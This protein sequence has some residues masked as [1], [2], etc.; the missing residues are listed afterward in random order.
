MGRAGYEVR[1]ASLS[2]FD[3]DRY[4]VKERIEL[5]C[6]ERVRMLEANVAIMLRKYFRK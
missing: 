3:G 4:K 2:N 6:Y 1:S 5:D